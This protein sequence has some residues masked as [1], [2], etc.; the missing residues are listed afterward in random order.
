MDEEPTFYINDEV[1]SSIC[2]SDTPNTKM[3]PLIYSPN[4][5]AE[6]SQTMTYSVLWATQNIKKDELYYRDFLHG[7]DET[8]WRSS[9]LLPWFNLF[10]EYFLA[11]HKKFQETPPSV[12]A[13]ALHA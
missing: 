11:E 6:D 3:S 2:H 5:E 1:G 10:D 8:K 9:R 7:I 13:M 12:D 4:C